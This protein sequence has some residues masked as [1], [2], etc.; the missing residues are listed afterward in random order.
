MVVE[1]SSRHCLLCGR[2]FEGRTFLCRDCSDRYRSREIPADV[3]KQ[4]YE[5]LDRTYPE[6]ANTYGDWNVPVALL[7]VIDRLPRDARILELGAGGGFLGVELRRRGFSNVIL[8]DMTTTALAAMRE[9]VPGCGLVGLDAASLPFRAGSFD[10]VISSDVIEHIPEIGQHVAEVARVLGPGGLY[11]LKTPNRLTAGVY[12]RLRGLHD[13]Y[14]WHPSMLSPRESRS[15]FEQHG[16]RIRFL[17]QP[18]LTGAQIAKLP[19]PRF[20][21][22]LAG[23]LPLAW[24]PVALRPHLEVVAKKTTG[25]VHGEP[26]KTPK[27]MR[28]TGERVLPDMPEMRVTYLQSRAAYEF[29]A[30]LV[31]GRRVLDCGSGEGYGSALLAERALEVVGLDRDPQAVEWANRTYAREGR[32]RF[33]VSE[34]QSL[35]FENGVFDLVTCF[36]VLEHLDDARAFLLETRRV[37]APGGALLL[38]TPNVLVAGERPNPHH[39]HDYRPDELEAL[40]REVF[41]D[42][43]VRG[44]FGSER[45]T[46]YRARNDRIVGRL[47]RLDPLGLHRRIPKRVL[48]PVHIGMTRLVRRR[49]NAGDQAAVTAITT[50]DFPIGNAPVDAAIDLLG[51]GKKAPG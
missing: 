7:R 31:E 16:F 45:V 40:L 42:V 15:T 25:T 35:P 46:Q 4:F 1:R 26:M 21:R 17:A 49:L 34:A 39:V 36:Q 22:P 33:V 6:R 50:A 38:T 23:R 10:V 44:V 20:L 2:V 11:L 47:L 27:S 8:T 19:G 30:G 43:E 12:Y 41:E 5:A 13:A 9:N 51:I 24:L 18:R 29:A 3:R 37:L 32:L 28:F 48:E 14:F